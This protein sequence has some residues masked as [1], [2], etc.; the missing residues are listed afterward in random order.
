MRKRTRQ[1]SER[2]DRNETSNDNPE[3]PDRRVGGTSDIPGLS[4][5]RE[6]ERERG[7]EAGRQ[8]DRQTPDK[9]RSTKTC[10][11]FK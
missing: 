2:G 5:W 8:A 3:N 9:M 6:R 1:E 11:R 10:I 7:R 4:S